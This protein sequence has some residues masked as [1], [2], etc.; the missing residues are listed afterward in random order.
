MYMFYHLV[1]K[2]CKKDKSEIN[3]S[4]YLQRKG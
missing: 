4:G 3:E 1:F 2:K